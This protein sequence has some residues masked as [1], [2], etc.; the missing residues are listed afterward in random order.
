[1]AMAD[2]QLHRLFLFVTLLAAAAVS[3]VSGARSV[4]AEPPSAYEMLEKFGFPKGILPVGVT[5]YKLRRSDGAFQVFMDRD[6][7][8][9]VDGGYR[10][11]YQRTI[12]GRVA[13]G[14]IRDLRGVSVKMFFVNWGIDQ[15]LMVDA[16]HLMF[17]VG[18]ISQA[19]TT[20][21]FLE[22][23]ECRG[24]RGSDGGQSAGGGSAV[25]AI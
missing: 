7:E 3:S 11:T 19:F 23:P 6:C 17:Y 1:M 10:L 4:P 25:A 18:P 13:G 14:S 21:N 12:S 2:T 15:V 24:C 20:D 22:S 8:F 5:G 9:E 16:D